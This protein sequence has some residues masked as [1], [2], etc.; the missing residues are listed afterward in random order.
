MI[1]E[2][3]YFQSKSKLFLLL[4][5]VAFIIYFLTFPIIQGEVEAELVKV[6]LKIEGLGKDFAKRRTGVPLYGSRF[7]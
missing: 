5:F 4:R 6:I 1:C 3:P 7:K 2:A